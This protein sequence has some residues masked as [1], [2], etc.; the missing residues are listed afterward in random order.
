MD[1]SAEA[2]APANPGFP[3]QPPPYPGN[4]PG[5]QYPGG[6]QQPPPPGPPPGTLVSGNLSNQNNQNIK[7]ILG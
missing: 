3:D 7:A 6:F 4:V 1:K 5:N 2:S